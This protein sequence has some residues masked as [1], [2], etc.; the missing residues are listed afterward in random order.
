MLA[1]Y[2][3]TPDFVQVHIV[4]ILLVQFGIGVLKALAAMVC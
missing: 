1:G 3:L 4:N 2:S